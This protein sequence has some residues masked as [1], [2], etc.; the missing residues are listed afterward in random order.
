[1]KQIILFGDGK[2]AEG[3]YFYF[4]NDSDFDVAAFCV[5][6][7][8]HTNKELF[9][10]PVVPFEQVDRLYPPDSYKMF[11]ALGYQ[12]LNN[13][14][15]EKYLA[16]KAKGYELASYI[17]SRATNFGNVEIG[18]NTLVLEHST[19][20]PLAKV[21]NNVFIMSGNHVGHH[22][23][24]RDHTYVCGHVMIAGNAVIGEGCF[25]GV[26]STIGHNVTIGDASL[27]GAGSL[28]LKDASAKSVFI[29]EGTDLYRLPSDYYTKFGKLE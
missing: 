26:N 16:A 10:L 14:R 3:V 24:V 7:A 18:D 29:Q 12:Q 1:M 11:V 20:Q 6:R 21:G 5:D 9:G 23:E 15:K 25:L 17:C 4:T 27:I 22:A 8:Y 19:I 13:L 2:I 28:I